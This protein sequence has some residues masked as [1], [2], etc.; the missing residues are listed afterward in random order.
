MLEINKFSSRYEVKRMIDEDVDEILVFCNAN[1]QYYEYCG[2]QNSRELILNDLHVTP[3]DVDISAKYYVGLYEKEELVAIM[4]LIEGYPEEDECFIGFFMMNN[5]LQGKGIGTSIIQELCHYLYSKGFKKVY[6]GIDRDNPQ[7]NHFWKKNGF[8]VI[9]EVD[10]DEGVILLAEKKL[11]DNELMLHIPAKEDGWF[12]VQ[13]MSDPKTMSYNAPWF[14]P[15]GC[16][17][18]ADKEFERLLDSWIDEQPKRF[19]AYLKRIEDGAF[20][21]DVNYHYNA[22]DDKYDMGIVILD[23]ERGKGYGKMGLSLLLERAFEVDGIPGLRND[24][25]TTRTAVCH[26][27]KAVGFKEVKWDGDIVVLELSK[28]D[29]LAA[30]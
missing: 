22:K 28:E 15:D 1:T 26:I 12:Y 2:K 19:Y 7:S 24:F 25:E 18:E 13:M 29:Y 20:V 14:P 4:D 10:R 5:A 23:S 30:K 3:P 6:L 16:I 27:H 8:K 17:P 9:R 11:S 21:G